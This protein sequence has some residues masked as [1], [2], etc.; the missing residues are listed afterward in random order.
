MSYETGTASS[1]VDLLTKFATWVASI[2]WTIDSSITVGSGWRLHIHKGS[3]YVNFRAAIAE[4]GGTAGFIDSNNLS[5]SGIGLYVGSGYS[6]ASD[7]RSQ[8]G[9]P[10]LNA[11]PYN[12][13]GV[14][15]AMNPGAITAYHFFGDS[16]SNNIIVVI[17][18]SSGIFSHFFFGT[19]LN[20]YGTWTGGQ[21]F[22]A[23]LAGQ[24]GSLLGCFTSSISGNNSGQLYSTYPPGF[25]L[26]NSAITYLK[27]N[28][29]AFTSKWVGIGN[30]ALYG[31]TGKLGCSSNTSTVAEC[32]IPNHSIL[33][34]RSTGQLSTQSLLLPI[35]LGVTRDIAGYTIVGDIPSIFLTNSCMKGFTP[36]AAYTWGSDN[37]VVFP[38]SAFSTLLTNFGFAVKK[39]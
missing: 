29:D 16:T 26:T 22:G 31:Y 23:S 33:V 18:R 3:I 20:K 27:I 25:N 14:G 19:S 12:P 21:Y 28:V 6:G 8:G 39:V 13:T 5:F 10:L 24:V 36:S 17:E 9:G 35:S 2:G 1:P 11:S 7:W 34:K 32:L 38:G 15:V 30:S 4:M 37:Y